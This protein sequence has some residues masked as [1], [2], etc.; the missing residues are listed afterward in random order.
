M[1]GR[2]ENKVRARLEVDGLPDNLNFTTLKNFFELLQKHVIVEI[3]DAISNVVISNIQ[4]LD[5]Q[6]DALWFRRSNSGSFLGAYVYSQGKWQQFFPAP[7]AIYWM[8]GDSRDVPEGYSLV[9]ID[10][11][12]MGT[13]TKEWIINQYKEHESEEYFTYFATIFVGL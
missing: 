8:Y 6:R 5:N 1:P 7:E 4:P 3:P 2:L 9:T 13:S 11:P 12:Q 10:T